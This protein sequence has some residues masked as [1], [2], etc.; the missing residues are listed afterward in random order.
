MPQRLQKLLAARGVGARRDIE[1]MIRR[2]NVRVNGRVACLGDRAE[3]GDDVRVGGRRI[4]VSSS[5]PT[6]AIVYHKPCGEVVSRGDR[7][8]D[9]IFARLPPLERGRWVAVGRL[10]INTS[11]ILLACS[12][13]ELAF[14]LMH[15][16]YRIPRT[17]RVRVRGK[18]GSAALRRLREGVMLGGRFARFESIETKGAPGGVNRWFE[19]ILCEGRNREVRRLWQSQGV[20][21]SRLIRTGF[22]GI[23]LDMRPGTWRELGAEEAADLYNAVDLAVPEF[24]PRP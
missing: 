5:V 14:R 16:S 2:G 11:G 4:D 6:R 9:T 12:D 23:S 15:P 8:R 19:V 17:Y 22:A 13:G 1:E 18:V 24:C 7:F 10:D 21:V 20:E 3:A